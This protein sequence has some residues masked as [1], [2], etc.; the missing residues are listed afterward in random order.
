MKHYCKL[1][2]GQDE[3]QFT[4][5]NDTTSDLI[6]AIHRSVTGAK[7]HILTHIDSHSS[8]IQ[9]LGKINFEG[10]LEDWDDIKKEIAHRLRYF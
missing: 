9:K 1:F 2:I 6:F 10:R 7:D 4:L 3:I 8:E 5:Q